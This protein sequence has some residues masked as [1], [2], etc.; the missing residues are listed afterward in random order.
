MQLQHLT[1]PGQRLEAEV[2]SKGVGGQGTDA[3]LS[4]TPDRLHSPHN[5][6]LVWEKQSEE[7]VESRYQTILGQGPQE[8][9]P[10]GLWYHQQSWLSCPVHPR[11]HRISGLGVKILYRPGIKALSA[12]CDVSYANSCAQ[13][14]IMPRCT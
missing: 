3:L 8:I 5:T 12:R 10:H 14:R 6:A 2:L 13:E 4:Q 11:R 1:T 9:H 7:P